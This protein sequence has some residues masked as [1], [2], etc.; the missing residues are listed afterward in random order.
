MLRHPLVLMTEQC[1]VYHRRQSPVFDPGQSPLRRLPL[2][3]ST[4][5]SLE[6]RLNIDGATRENRNGAVTDAVP[7]P[8][9]PESD[10]TSWRREMWRRANSRLLH[11]TYS[12]SAGTDV[13]RRVEHRLRQGLSTTVA[14]IPQCA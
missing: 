7:S 10:R 14:D 2:A 4:G 11:S 1:A 5:C 12:P 9:C 3:Q 13:A 6:H 8:L